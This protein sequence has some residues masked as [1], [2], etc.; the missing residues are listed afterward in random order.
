[1]GSSL[2]RRFV[3][4]VAIYALARTLVEVGRYYGFEEGWHAGQPTLVLLTPA[5]AAADY[6]AGV[7]RARQAMA[8]GLAEA[9]F[10]ANGHDIVEDLD[11][12]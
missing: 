7:A 11:A 8:N 2:A 4:G 10:R 9:R 1:M 3:A 12:R 5:D 6:L